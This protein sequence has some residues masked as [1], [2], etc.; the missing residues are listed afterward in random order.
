MLARKYVSVV[1]ISFLAIALIFT[2]T[3]IAYAESTELTIKDTSIDWIT[4]QTDYKKARFHVTTNKGTYDFLLEGNSTKVES[5]TIILIDL[6]ALQE[7]TYTYAQSMNTSI[8]DILYGAPYVSAGTSVEAMHI[9]LGPA[10][11]VVLYG[12]AIVI[13]IVVF[14]SFL[15]PF[16]ESI[17]SGTFLYVLETLL[18]GI[19]YASLPW[20]YVTIYGNDHNVDGSINLYIP[21]DTVQQVLV[22]DGQF[23]LA[24]LFNWWLIARAQ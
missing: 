11:A 13:A 22:N 2:P 3:Q 12:F 6:Y 7:E 23:Y 5:E 9:H 20:V 8:P 14:I 10:I 18:N 21:Y 16:L 15:I 24:T 1:L 17:L 4:N 19:F